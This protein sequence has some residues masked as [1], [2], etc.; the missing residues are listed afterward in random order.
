[1]KVDFKQ[2]VNIDGQVYSGVSHIADD[3]KGHWYLLA[4]EKDGLATILQEPKE[5]EEAVVKRGR[6]PKE[7][8]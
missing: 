2:P 1:V 4:L 6:K 3:L 8:E 5:E 7:E